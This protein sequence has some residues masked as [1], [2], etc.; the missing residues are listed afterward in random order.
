LAVTKSIDDQIEAMQAV[1]HSVHKTRRTRRQV[2]LSFDE[3]N[4]WYRARE[5]EHVDGK[6][7]FAPHLIEEHYNLEDALVVAGFLNSFIRHADSVK[8]ANLAQIVNVIAPIL[9]RGDEML[10]QTIFYPFEMMSKRR[11]GNAL[12][13]AIEGSEYQAKTHGATHHLDA[14]AILDGNQLHTFLVNRSLTQPMEVHVNA[15]GAE[16]TKLVSAELLHGNDPQANNTYEAPNT[17][18]AYSVDDVCLKPE[19]AYVELPPLS[20]YAATFE[21]NR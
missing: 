7:K 21:V 1:C 5:G 9:T 14:S 18:K 8:I 6:G 13:V 11:N 20:V 15:A 3:W 4:V 16:I 17:V 12:R 2:Q 19:G 10:L